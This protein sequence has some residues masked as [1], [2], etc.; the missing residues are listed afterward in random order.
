MNW[1]NK[2][3]RWLKPR[4]RLWAMYNELGYIPWHNKRKPYKGYNG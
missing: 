3:Y 4:L 1:M 2:L